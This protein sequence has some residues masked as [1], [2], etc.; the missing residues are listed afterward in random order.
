MSGITTFN[1]M[2]IWTTRETFVAI[3]IANVF[4][5][6]TT[7]T[8]KS[9]PTPHVRTFTT[10][11]REVE[12]N[13][14]GTDRTLRGL[15]IILAGDVMPLGLYPEC[16]MLCYVERDKDKVIAETRR[17]AFHQVRILP[18]RLRIEVEGTG[19]E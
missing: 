10:L 11:N 5:W 7:W 14:R 12:Q 13:D 18:T 16:E 1:R 17:G 6:A 15:R 9:T 8:R 4:G 2:M 19:E 3:P